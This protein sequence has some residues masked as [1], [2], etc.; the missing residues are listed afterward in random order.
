MEFFSF[1]YA[2]KLNKREKVER[3]PFAMIEILHLHLHT[4]HVSSF[5][6]CTP[7]FSIIL[8]LKVIRIVIENNFH[9]LMCRN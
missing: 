8:L 6:K 5:V 9:L 7:D 2:G 3:F 4:A 1:V